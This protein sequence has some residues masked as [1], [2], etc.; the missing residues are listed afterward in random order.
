MV[1]DNAEL[2]DEVLSSADID[3]IASIL[4]IDLK[5]PDQ[6]KEAARKVI[7]WF[8]PTDAERTAANNFVKR[9]I[10]DVL[11]DPKKLALYN[12][13]IDGVTGPGGRQLIIIELRVRFKDQYWSFSIT[14]NQVLSWS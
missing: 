13:L 12:K 4:G 7:E 14:F 2:I 1:K 9:M 5:D 10:E 11:A 8:N 3:N 6:M